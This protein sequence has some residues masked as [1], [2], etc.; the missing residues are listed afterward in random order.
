MTPEISPQMA[1]TLTQQE[2]PELPIPS[3]VHSAFKLFFVFCV[4]VC[5][6]VC[7]HV[8]AC[9]CEGTPEHAYLVHCKDKMWSTGGGNGKLPQDTC[10]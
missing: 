9:V 4:C 2:S 7:T 10:C 3:L 6:H 5:V 1:K 8:H